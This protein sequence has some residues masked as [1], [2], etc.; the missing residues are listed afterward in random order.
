MIGVLIFDHSAFTLFTGRLIQSIA[1]ASVWVVGFATLADNIAAE[2]LGKT[3]GVVTAAIA[4]GTSGGPLLAGI[5]YELVGYWAAWS[6]AFILILL[7]VVMRVL[8]LEKPRKQ[9]SPHKTG[10]TEACVCDDDT[11]HDPLLSPCTGADC[12]GQSHLSLEKTGLQFYLSLFRNGRFFGGVICYLC[13]AILVSSFDTT[14]PLHVRS[15]F[16]WESLPAGLLFAV[17]Q[18]PAIVLAVF[19]GWLKD[20]VGTRHPTW[21]GFA[22]LVPLLWLTGVPGDERFPWANENGRGPI[23]YSVTI[24]GAGM[25]ICLLDGVGTLE[26]T[27]KALRNGYANGT[28]H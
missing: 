11:E 15:T 24:L 17:F 20:R 8:M 2:D 1:S 26:T 13:Y 28:I 7:D 12:H 23:L 10:R 5:L 4:A 27:R 6:S 9:Q 22:T 16:H 18:G 21:V 3:Y 25:A 19:V 14:L